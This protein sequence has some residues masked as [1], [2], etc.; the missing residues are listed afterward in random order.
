M[1]NAFMVCLSWWLDWGVVS[2]R[3][4]HRRASWTGDRPG[5]GRTLR[6]GG[7]WIRP[8]RGAGRVSRCRRHHHHHARHQAP[9]AGLHR[10]T[11]AGWCRAHTPAPR[12]RHQRSSCPPRRSP[13]SST[14]DWTA[15]T[16]RPESM[17][18]R[19]TSSGGCSPGRS[20]PGGRSCDR[21]RLATTQHPQPQEGRSRSCPDSL[22]TPVS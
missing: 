21:L 7:R 17:G 12:P 19:W 22:W 5:L 10:R 9:T 11:H 8:R 20:S 14:A 4:C 2:G 18:P 6:W 3:A 13:G 15:S 1:A 16:R